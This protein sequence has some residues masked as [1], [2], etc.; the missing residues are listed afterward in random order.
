MSMKSCGVS[1]PLARTQHRPVALL[2][3]VALICVAA[4]S[5]AAGDAG[6]PGS[7]AWLTPAAMRAAGVPMLLAAAYDDD[8]PPDSTADVEDYSG[9]NGRYIFALSKGVARSTMVT[10]LKPPLFILTIPLDIA[11]LPFALIGGFF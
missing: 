10:P 6:E 1:T 9:Y 5:P 2:A 3:A 4:A 7:E 8:R 11:L